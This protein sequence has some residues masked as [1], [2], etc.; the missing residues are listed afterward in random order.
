MQFIPS[1]IRN[2]NGTNLVL[3]SA[4]QRASTDHIRGENP[5]L[6]RQRQILHQELLQAESNMFV[7]L[8]GFYLGTVGDVELNEASWGIWVLNN[9]ITAGRH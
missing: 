2:I 6:K 1:A 3:V 5:V 4:P 8:V 7:D 9:E